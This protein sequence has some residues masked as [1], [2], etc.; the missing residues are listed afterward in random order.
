MEK[1]YSS[2]QMV[3]SMKDILNKEKEMAMEDITTL[4]VMCILA[5]G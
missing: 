4:M 5:I 1:E 3:A 2:G